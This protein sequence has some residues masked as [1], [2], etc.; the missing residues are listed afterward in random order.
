[1]KE[2]AAG[3][4]Y[5][6]LAIEKL[7]SW[8]VS[9]AIGTNYFNSSGIF[10]AIEEQICQLYGNSI[11]I[12]SDGDPNFDDASLKDYTAT[13]STDW[14]TIPTSNSRVNSKVQKMVGTLKLATRKVVV[15]DR[16]REWDECL[17]EIL[18]CY[19][20][21]PGIDG[22]S[23]FEI[24]FGVRPRFAVESPQIYLAALNTDFD[25]EFEIAIADSVNKSR[26]VPS[27]QEKWTNKF[28]LGAKVLVR[29]GRKETGSKIESKIGSD[30]S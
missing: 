12:L 13:A 7:S 18:G 4:K 6:L 10:K 3:N 16:N 23:P 30:L 5:I 11:R 17:G 25:R 14:K 1:M 19:R 29:R 2:T 24:F 9:S 26:I 22:K 27:T 8:P 15:S 21:R 28:E 20:R